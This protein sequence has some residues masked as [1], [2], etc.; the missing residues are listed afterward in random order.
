MITSIIID[1]EINAQKTLFKK[2]SEFQERISVVAQ[3]SNAESAIEFLKSNIVDVVFLDIEMPEMD[4]LEFLSSFSQRGFL[5]VF[6]SESGNYA[7]N[8]IKMEAV[9]YLLKPTDNSELDACLTRIEKILHKLH[10]AAKLEDIIIKQNCF[11][12]LPLKIKLLQDGKLV[13]YKPEEILYSEG[14]GSYSWVYF[15]KNKRVLITKNLKQLEEDLPEPI[16]YRVHNSYI[17]NLNK[18]ISYNKNE[19]VVVLENDIVIPVS[20]QKR[21]N[22]LS[23][24]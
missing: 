9:Y 24:I 3:F 10:Y 12:E 19:G 1:D 21:M 13:F 15:N 17:I 18:I 22:I 20:R 5:V 6:I 8:A 7:I 11:K 23:K 4:G 16:F 2:L 14:D